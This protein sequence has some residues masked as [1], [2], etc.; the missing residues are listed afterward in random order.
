RPP[1][2]YRPA[3]TDL[4]SGDWDRRYRHYRQQDS[5]DGGYRLAIAGR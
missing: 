2:G 1:S 3:T 4:A 5:I